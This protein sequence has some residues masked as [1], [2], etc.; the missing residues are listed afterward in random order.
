MADMDNVHLNKMMLALQS[1][2]REYETDRLRESYP[3]RA[4]AHAM[5]MLLARFDRIIQLLE[6][7]D[8]RGGE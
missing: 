8:A 4:I 3:E 2:D 6:V 1:M 5:P 7:R